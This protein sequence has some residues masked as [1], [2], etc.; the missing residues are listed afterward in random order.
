ML[1]AAPR[2][3]ARVRSSAV[4]VP[5]TSTRRVAAQ[6]LVG[7]R[8]VRAPR[9]VART[10]PHGAYAP[11][12]AAQRTHPSLIH[13]QKRAHH[14]LHARRAVAA[15]LQ[16]GSRHIWRR[17]PAAPLRLRLQHRRRLRAAQPGPGLR[18]RSSCRRRRRRRH[19]PH[20]WDACA[21]L[22]CCCRAH[23]RSVCL[24]LL[25]AWVAARPVGRHHARGVATAWQAR[26]ARATREDGGTLFPIF[27]TA[28][29]SCLC[30]SR[31][32]LPRGMAGILDAP[33]H[34]R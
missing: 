21:C 9:R 19:A 1:C 15:R 24:A 18:R 16:V 27:V 6:T 3:R 29:G 12:P 34:A 5:A 30:R 10:A 28:R 8:V 17:R 20:F 4:A 2:G 31:S 25:A 23:A 26:A 7:T 14:R 13:A 33:L 32:A 22:R 11:H